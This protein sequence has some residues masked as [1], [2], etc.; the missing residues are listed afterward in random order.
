ML[1]N[2]TDKVCVPCKGGIL[3]L[4][5]NEARVFLKFT[6]GWKLQKKATR[7]RRIFKFDDFKSSLTFIQQVGKIA[8]QE[9]HH[10]DFEFGW[11][12]ANIQI[13]T[14]KINGL[15]ENDFILAAKINLI[16]A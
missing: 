1:N 7:L 3:S 15:H 10:P 16:S 13:Y 9:G 11:G 6:A 5:P 8:E 12:Y 14:H 4:T 2:L